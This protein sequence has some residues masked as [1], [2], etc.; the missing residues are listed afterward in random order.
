VRVAQSLA[1]MQHPGCMIVKAGDSRPLPARAYRITYEQIPRYASLLADLRPGLDELSAA[2]C[3]WYAGRWDWD[4]CGHLVRTE[5]RPAAPPARPSQPSEAD[6]FGSLAAR[7]G[8]TVPPI[9]TAVEEIFEQAGAER[10][11]TRVILDRLPSG[12]GEMT[13]KR[14]S[15]LLGGVG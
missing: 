14:L 6:E 15:M 2:P 1:R 11:H 7:L 5:T 9:L 8:P 4:R 12:I 13:A 3:Q 10:L